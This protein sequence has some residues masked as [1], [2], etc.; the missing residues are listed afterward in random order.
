MTA[1]CTILTDDYIPG[2][3]ALVKSLQYH[4]PGFN[5]S[6]FIFRDKQLTKYQQI[7]DIYPY[8]KF[9][10]YKNK[11]FYDLFIKTNG[12]IRK[13]FEKCLYTLDVFDIDYNDKI[14]FIDTDILCT[15]NISELL[16]VP[17]CLGF[18]YATGAQEVRNTENLFKYK[19]EYKKK[20]KNTRFNAGLFIV[21]SDT[22]Y[23]HNI[24]YFMIK[25]NKGRFNLPEQKIMNRFFTGNFCYHIPRTYNALKRFFHDDWFNQKA[26]DKCKLIHYVGAKPWKWSKEKGYNKI[27]KVW[28]DFYKQEC[29]SDT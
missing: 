24:K 27:N 1:F 17:D 21:N 13:K 6:F 28:K 9:I 26:L 19:M 10:N 4:N 11:L 2:F 5:Y 8:V 15:G 20:S 22:K 23:M 18:S 29:K 7:L 16:K 3:H 12:T 14:I 25:N